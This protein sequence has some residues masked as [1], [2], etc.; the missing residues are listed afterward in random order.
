MARLG[1]PKAGK[2]VNLGIRLT[3][4]DA[5]NLR[6]IAV[7]ENITMSDFVR[8]SIHRRMK[9]LKEMGIWREETERGIEKGSADNDRD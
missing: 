9:R 8:Q 7:T 5:A 3:E 1:R 4:A 6:R 2:T